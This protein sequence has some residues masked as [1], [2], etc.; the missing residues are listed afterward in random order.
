M[1]M[2]SHNLLRL[3]NN[4]MQRYREDVDSHLKCV[5]SLPSQC[6]T[7]TTCNYA[8]THHTYYVMHI[9]AMNT[10]LVTALLIMIDQANKG[11]ASVPTVE[12]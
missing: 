12:Q 3:M 2:H 6:L 9:N 11:Q 7:F 5:A 10:I 4:S 8:Q 1:R